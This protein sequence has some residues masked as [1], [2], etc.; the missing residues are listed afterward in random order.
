MASPS[1]LFK[2]EPFSARS[3]QN[4]KEQVIYFGSPLNFNDPYDCALTP[5]IKSPSDIDI[6]RLRKHYGSDPR[7]PDITRVKFK[8]MADEE[9]RKLIM[10]IGLKSLQ[11]GITEFLS[12]KGVSCFSEANDSLLMW[13]HYADSG[14]GFCLEFRTD[15]SPFEKLQQVRYSEQMPEVDVVPILCGDSNEAIMD[16]YRLKAED[17][18]YEKEWRCI[19]T[20]AGTAFCYEGDVL[21]GVYLGPGMPFS[22]FE[23]IAMVLAGQ[24]ESVQLW[25]GFRS[26]STFK[27]DFRP[28]TYTTHLEARRLGLL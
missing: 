17:W 2:Y 15:K 27:V 9:L 13:S 25:Q 23:I 21:T 11:E 7:V 5:K 1:R 19:H 12:S 8:T 18:R 4:L 14:K 20:K 3:L 10:V 24:N 26:E 16:L 6:A 28:V 22:Q